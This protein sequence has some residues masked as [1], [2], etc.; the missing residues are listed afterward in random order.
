MVKILED[1]HNYVPYQ[2]LNDIKMFSPIAMSGDQLTIARIRTAQEVR[3]SSSTEY[4]LRGLTCFAGD[5]H[6]KVN[7][8]EVNQF[9][10]AMPLPY[11][12]YR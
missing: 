12:Y 11:A 8:M 6:A 3:V 1:L 2:T 9:V 10:F 7:F 5:W 4:A